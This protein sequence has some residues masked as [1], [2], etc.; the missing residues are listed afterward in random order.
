MQTDLSTH[1]ARTDRRTLPDRGS[2]LLL[3]SILTGFLAASAAPTPLYSTYA[4]EWGFASITVTVVFGVENGLIWRLQR[5]LP[6]VMRRILDSTLRSLWRR[7]GSERK[8]LGPAK[9]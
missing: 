2:F 3:A 1:S 8:L 4:R 5:W 9:A 6:G 7:S